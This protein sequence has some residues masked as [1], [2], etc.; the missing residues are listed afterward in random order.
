MRGSIIGVVLLVVVATATTVAQKKSVKDDLTFLTRDGCVNTPDMVNNLDDAL[1][2]LGWANDYQYIDIGKLPKTD[3]R[4]GY[5]T[6]TV[7]WKG[8]DTFGMPVPTARF[9]EPR[10][11][12][13]KGGVP[14]IAVI[15][16]KLQAATGL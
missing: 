5:P 2:A 11:R 13:Y 9:P 7:L 6:P 16:A 8:K 3:A 15:T 4:T 10:W 1:K 12:V 14:S